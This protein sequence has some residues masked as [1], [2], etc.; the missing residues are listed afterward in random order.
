MNEELYAPDGNIFRELTALRE[1]LR[2]PRFWLQTRRQLPRG[3]GRVVVI[4]GF[5]TGDGSTAVL[6]ATIRSLGYDV[7]GWGLGRN[8]GEVEQLLPRVAEVVR[9]AALDGPVHLVGWS[10]G[11]YLAREVARDNP[12][13]VLQ[14]IT[15]ASPIIGGPKYTAAAGY[16]R[17]RGVDLDAIEAKIEARNA[18]PLQVPVLALYSERDNVV[19]PGACIDHHSPQVEHVRVNQCQHASFGFNPRVLGLVAEQLASTA[20]A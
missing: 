6:R 8:L 18:T 9:D 1:A 16:Y 2:L 11:G 17:N 13:R 19:C 5:G 12:E 4:P 15:L 3:Q 20:H 10:L 14:V 7:R